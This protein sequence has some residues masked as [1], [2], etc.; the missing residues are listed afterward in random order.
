MKN[1]LDVFSRDKTETLGSLLDTSDKTASS[2]S[3]GKASE[4]NVEASASA[5]T[6]RE[7]SKKT[8]KKTDSGKGAFSFDDTSKESAAY[9]QEQAELY[10]IIF[11]PETWKGVVAAPGDLAFAM[12][13][14]EHWVLSE[15][16]K[17]TLA[18]SGAATFRA[19]AATD[20]KWIALTL[21]SVSLI[22][23]YG[24]RIMKDLAD[25]KA[26]AKNVVKLQEVKS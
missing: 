8:R 6:I 3:A 18:A 20:P 9:Q 1:I 2:G 11:K 10:A 23:I 13:K 5:A 22:T 14:R 25:K 16:E 12:T 15:P 4:I 26:D 24:G 7:A 17:E 21:F 19:F